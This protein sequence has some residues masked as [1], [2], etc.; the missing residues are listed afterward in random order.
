MALMHTP[1]DGSKQ[2]FSVGLEPIEESCWLETDTNLVAHLER[3]AEL[4]E[5]SHDTVFRQEAGTE[6][7][8]QEVLDLVLAH[9]AAHHAST[10]VVAAETVALKYGASIVDLNSRPALETAARLIQEDLVL[11]RA[12]DHGYR[13]V[14][15][16]LCFPSSWS[17]VEKHGQTMRAIHE[18]VPGFND[19]RMGTVVGRIFDNLK[20][21]QLVG[22]YNWAIYDDS[23][24]H[25]PESRQLMPN[26]ASEK[27]NALAGL[28]I[29][30]ERQTLRRLPV[31]GDILFTIKIHHD[32]MHLLR[33]R[34]D[35]ASLAAS[36]EQQLCALDPEQ[37]RYKGLSAHRDLI[38]NALAEIS[39]CAKP[40]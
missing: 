21:G 13:L 33:Q 20:V 32:P 39:T 3:K 29:R 9:L 11:M 38:V 30:V 14:A 6:K 2:P 12:S 19:G 25:H 27:R 28:F 15:A 22:R 31:S 7:A 8:Q 23:D 18:T 37:L 16:C 4:L 34:E 24:L 35:S 1:Y 36:L 26:P 5:R 17:L 40:A 10:H